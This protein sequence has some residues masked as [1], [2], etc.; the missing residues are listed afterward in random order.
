[1]DFTITYPT[2][3][4]GEELLNGIADHNY[5][6]AMLRDLV[7]EKRGISDEAALA[8]ILEVVDPERQCL[9]D[10]LE[11]IDIEREAL[12]NAAQDYHD[13]HLGAYPDA[14][15]MIR[16][17]HACDCKF[18]TATTNSRMSSLSKLAFCGLATMEGSPYFAGFFGG[19][20]CEGGKMGPHFFP[21]ILEKGGFAPEDC[22]M[23]GD[24]PLWDLAGAK[25]AGIEQVVLPRRDQGEELAVEEDGGI[26]VRSLAIVPRLLGLPSA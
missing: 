16:T 25:A 24:D 20:I 15:E 6:L 12:W 21:T 8:V 2:A 4:P 14:V 17:L 1:M 7:A 26:Y 10:I 3:P 23:I 18:Y 19:D 22:L 9:F 11:L 5:Y 13:E